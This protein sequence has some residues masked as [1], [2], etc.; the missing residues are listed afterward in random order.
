MISFI[1]SSDFISRAYLSSS[2]QLYVTS[3]IRAGNRIQA[4][5]AKLRI[6]HPIMSMASDT[7][8]YLLNAIRYGNVDKVEELLK[9]GTCSA[10]CF[11]KDY[12][13]TPALIL[14][15]TGLKDHETDAAGDSVRCS[16][17]KIL[18]RHG[19]NVDS[20]DKDQM[21]AALHSAQRGFL[22]CLQFLKAS[23]ADLG[24]RDK[25]GRNAVICSVIHGRL[26]CLKYLIDVMPKSWLNCKTNTGSTPLMA[27]AKVKWFDCVECLVKAGADINVKDDAG[28]TALMFALKYNNSKASKLFLENGA[29]INTIAQDG[30]TPLTIA[31]HSSYGYYNWVLNLLK[32]GADLTLSFQDQDYLHEMVA[33]SK[34][35]VVRRMVMN[36]CPPLDRLCKEHMFPFSYP[37]TPISPLA[38]ALL[39]KQPDIAMYFIANKFFTRYDIKQLCWDT[40]IIRCLGDEEENQEPDLNLITPQRQCLA[41]ITFLSMQPQS[42][43]TLSLMAVS[44]ALNHS[45]HT[46]S[47]HR[48]NGTTSGLHPQSLSSRLFALRL[49]NTKNKSHKLQTRVESCKQGLSQRTNKSQKPSKLTRREIV[50]HLGLPPALKRAL[51]FETPSSQVCCQQWSGIRLQENVCYEAMNCTFCG[52]EC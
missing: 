34:K 19:A 40:E 7:S 29:V 2:T 12:L 50:Q 3:K 26:D 37:Q 38:V 39:S 30:F 1:F 41:I 52:G 4:T 31:Y 35:A 14:C 51:L 43:F 9:S 6:K 21:T 18:M 49:S 48:S 16:L 47:K 44:S 46:H 13:S 23:G 32:A 36:G 33:R 5:C 20:M 11:A 8:S 27:A 45:S 22:S 25:D 24:K 10:L 17:L 15:V 42:L 28:Y